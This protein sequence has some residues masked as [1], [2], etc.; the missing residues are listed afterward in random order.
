MKIS[1]EIREHWTLF[2][3][4][5]LP[6]ADHAALCRRLETS[7][8]LAATLEADARLHQSLLDHYAAQPAMTAVLGT[9]PAGVYGNLSDAEFVERCLGA[10]SGLATPL[11]GQELRAEEGLQ[12]MQPS[13]PTHPSVAPPVF[14]LVDGITFEELNAVPPIAIEP[15]PVCETVLQRNSQSWLVRRLPHLALALTLLVSL[16][17][18]SWWLFGRGGRSSDSAF[19][20]VGGAKSG[21]VLAGNDR[22]KQGADAANRADADQLVNADPSGVDDSLAKPVEGGQIDQPREMGVDDRVPAK[23]DAPGQMMAAKRGPEDF[24]RVIRGSV[25]EEPNFI[26]DTEPLPAGRQLTKIPNGQL[27]H[28]RDAQW[29]AEPGAWMVPSEPDAG[30]VGNDVSLVRLTRGEAQLVLDN[31]LLV[32][33]EAPATFRFVSSNKLSLVEG[34]YLIES[35]GPAAPMDFTVETDSFEMAL[36]NAADF[37]VTTTPEFGTGVEM[38]DGEARLTP[39]SGLGQPE[40]V[41]KEGI[42]VG[43]FLPT[44]DAADSRP[45]AAALMQRDGKFVGQIT[46]FQMPLQISSAEVFGVTL[47]TVVKRMREAPENFDRDWGDVVSRLDQ[48]KA[49]NRKRP[50]LLHEVQF[51]GDL[52]PAV[53]ELQVKL[54]RGIPTNGLFNGEMIRQFAG[55]LNVNGEVVNLDNMAELRKIQEQLMD[56]LNQL[57]VERQQMHGKR[58]FRNPADPD[59]LAQQLVIQQMQQIDMLMRMAQG[60]QAGMG[61]FAINGAGPPLAPEPVVAMFTGL[62]TPEGAQDREAIIASLRQRLADAFESDEQRAKRLQEM[63]DKLNE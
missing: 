28:G 58:G 31:G 62:S 20:E 8:E 9:L 30:T 23:M 24:P 47:Q 3:Q 33:M 18:G 19:A 43:H 39:R 25:E 49:T 52:L 7:P 44:V 11:Q 50:G 59:F 14:D 60:I 46:V 54:G 42:Y 56:E 35:R 36:D 45:E 22:D 51:A 21:E 41:S 4:G 53:P 48:L 32:G 10:V 34:H 6:A 5:Q 1:P 16:A 26:K 57:R 61:N 40:R 55:Q 17:V 29:Q 12:Q 38:L 63:R 27:V 37:F 15:P 2:L 13:E